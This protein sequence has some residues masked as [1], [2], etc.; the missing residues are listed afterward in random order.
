MS[1]GRKCPA[2][3]VFWQAVQRL[4]DT[5]LMTF[6]DLMYDR[7]NL[8]ISISADHGIHFRDLLCDLFSVTL[9]QT[10]G[11]DQSFEIC[12][13]FETAHVDQGL[14]TFFHGITDKTTGIDNDDICLILIIGDGNAIFCDHRKH[15]LGIDQVL[16]TAK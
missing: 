1:A 4:F 7:Y 5:G 11:H 15:M 16:I 3:I 14:D 12:G 2:G 9:C 6:H 13:F 8:I 10:A